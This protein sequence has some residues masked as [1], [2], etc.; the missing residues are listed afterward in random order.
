MQGAHT[1]VVLQVCRIIIMGGHPGGV[2]QFDY[3]DSADS[4]MSRWLQS[5]GLQHLASPTASPTLDPRL[6]QNLLMQVIKGKFPKWLFLR[7]FCYFKKQSARVFGGV[8]K[9]AKATKVSS[10][11][12]GFPLHL[13][14]CNYP[15]YCQSFNVNFMAR[16]SKIW[17]NFWAV[18]KLTAYFG[19]E[20]K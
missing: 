13:H 11:I 5:A 17:L 1:G 14:L 7:S 10:I 19:N 12:V 6:L 2:P 15:N 9:S 18:L 16:I 4:V 20:T 8:F 3:Y